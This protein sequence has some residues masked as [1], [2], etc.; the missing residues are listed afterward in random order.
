M[1]RGFHHLPRR[2]ETSGWGPRGNLAQRH[3]V[4]G[5]GASAS[6]KPPVFG[7]GIRRFESC[8]P[9]QGI[10]KL[11]LKDNPLLVFSGRAHPALTEAICA[12]LQIEM[13]HLRLGNFSD[14]EIYCQIQDNV[15]G[16]DVFIVQPTG[17]P[18]NDS[19][20]ELLIMLDAFRRASP[21]RRL[22]RHP[23]P[24]LCPPGPQG[25][26]AGAD[27][28]Q[29][30]RQPDHHRRRRPPAHHRPPRRPDPGLLRHPGRPPLRGA[31]SDRGDPPQ[32]PRPAD[33]GVAGRRRGRAGAGVREAARGRPGDHGQA[34]ARGE[35][36]RDHERHRSGRGRRLRR[37]STTS[38]TPPAPW[39]RRPRR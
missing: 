22:R 6:G 12:Y 20:M 19:L 35:Q 14:G 36:G 39:S 9:S 24:R 37:S 3:D 8:R 29:A 25:R 32:G 38:S 11:M 18:A 2:G 23:L 26:A 16:A 1:T 21:A 17:P 28:G 7:T 4:N 31:G 34:A 30:G 27:H 5:L 13:G 10:S 15:R 33:P